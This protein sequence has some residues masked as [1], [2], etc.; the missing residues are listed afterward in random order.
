MYPPPPNISSSELRPG[1]GWYVFAVLL[2]IV[3]IALGVG[4][5]G[6]GV[7]SAVKSMDVGQRF[8]AD[9]TV[10]ARLTPSPRG[11]IF[12]RVVDSGYA[13]EAECTVTGPSG[14]QARLFA[15]SGTFT[16]TSAGA[17]WR[18]IFVVEA[19]ET[20]AH[21]IVCRSSETNV[22]SVGKDADLGKLFGGIFGGIAFLLVLPFAGVVIGVIIAVVVGVKRGNHRRRLIAERFPPRY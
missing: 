17:T 1:R 16:V 18:E 8:N 21:R 13:P 10:T 9:E 3:L 6:L 12:A 7:F 11:A 4:G 2:A 15:P 20:G 5:F 22:F 14:R 19:T